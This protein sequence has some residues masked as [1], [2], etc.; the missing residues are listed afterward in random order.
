ME[1]MPNNATVLGRR[2]S[3][4]ARSQKSIIGRKYRRDAVEV[5]MGAKTERSARAF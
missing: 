3:P 4:N 2:K 5:R 1:V